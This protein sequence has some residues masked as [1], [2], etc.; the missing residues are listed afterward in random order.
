VRLGRPRGRL[1]LRIRRLRPAVADVV[2]DRA[3]EQ[4]RLLQGHPHVAAQARL[5]YVAHVHPVQGD[6]PGGDVV[7][8]GNQV[9]QAGLPGA[10]RAEHG[11]GLPR[12]DDEA[13]AL[14]HR[15]GPGAAVAEADVLER[16]PPAGGELGQRV[17]PLGQ[18]RRARQ[19]LL[20]PLG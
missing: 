17:R 13:D 14:Q 20:D 5:V 19:H 2:P 18:V 6:P 16:H 8:A 3:A 12:L 4:H 15:V 1:H 7:E 11:H 9:Q 10:G